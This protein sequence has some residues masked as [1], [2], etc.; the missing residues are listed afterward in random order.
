MI[1][2]GIFFIKKRETSKKQYFTFLTF[3]IPT[4]EDLENT[5]LVDISEFQF[6]KNRI[7]FPS[8]R[9]L[10]PLLLTRQASKDFLK[11]SLLKISSSLF[12]P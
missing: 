7:Y 10:T 2:P 1:W 6:F 12:L 9:A 3:P 4:L 5:K 8:Q 11:N